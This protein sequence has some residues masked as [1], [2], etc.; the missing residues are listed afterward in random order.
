MAH[1]ARKAFI[2]PLL[3]K[4]DRP[5]EVVWDAGD[6]D[7]WSTGRR[8]WLAADRTA[9]HG[10]VVQDDA[11]IPR[12]LVAGIEKALEHVP[13]KSPLCLY[14]GRVR[15]FRQLVQHMVDQT[16]GDTS[17]LTMNELHWGVGIVLPTE[18]IGPC[19]AWGDT[20]P[21]I[22]NYDRRIGRWLQHQGL[23]VYYPWP[24][25]VDHRDSPSLVPGRGSSGRRA[26]RFIGADASALD[27]RWDGTVVPMPTLNAAN[28]PAAVRR[29]M[30]GNV[31]RF[32]NERYPNLHIPKLGV[33]FRDGKAEVTGPTAIAVLQSPWWRRRGVML[34]SEVP[35]EPQPATL[36]ATQPA[37]VADPAPVEP[38]AAP[39][40]DTPDP[41]GGTVPD[42]PASDVTAWVGAD[43][44]RARAALTA[45][46]ERD[47][48]RSTLIRDLTKVA[49][50]DEEQ[51]NG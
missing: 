18:L 39:A 4:L 40:P 35:A 22:P 32:V 5:A 37:A 44:D 15:P 12:D 38:D 17:W 14:A 11:I 7:R 2:P 21:E 27:Q 3:D 20:R 30:G 31:M 43:P 41:Q 8:A 10:L 6:N 29:Q 42:G 1:P 47:R 25:L 51:G 24:S 28:L 36:T 34:A 46:H 13:A 50:A 33:R 16:S 19:I 26:H 23:T 9:S 45:E 49:T 48:P